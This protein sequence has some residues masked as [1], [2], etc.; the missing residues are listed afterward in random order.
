MCGIAGMVAASGGM[1]PSPDTLRTMLGMIRYRGPDGYGIYTDD[2]AALGQARLSIIDLSSGAQPMSNEDGSIWIVFNGEIFNYV[3]LRDELERLGHRYHTRSD[4]ETIIHAYEQWGDRAWVMFNGQFAAALWDVRKRQLTLARDRVGIAPLHYARVRDARGERIVF[5]SEVK[6]IFAEGGLKPEFDPIG[7][8]RAFT[9]WS[10]PAPTTVWRGV[11]SV[12]PGQVITFDESLRAHSRKFWSLKIDDRSASG[13]TDRD[14]AGDRLESRLQDAVRLRLRADVPVGSYLSGGLDSSVIAHLI[15]RLHTGQLHTFSLRFS[16]PAFDETPQQHR[17]ANI[18]GTDHH[19]IVCDSEAIRN[20]LA[21]VVWHCETPL[22]RLGPVPMYLLSGLVRKTGIKVVMTGEGADEFLCGYHIFRENA[23]RRFWARGP[24]S[25]WRPS[26][27][28]NLHPYITGGNQR[29]AMWMQFFRKNLGA[30]DDPFYSH[31]VRWENSVWTTRLLSAAM[32]ERMDLPHTRATLDDALPPD[33]KNSS[34]LA[35][36]QAIEITTFMSSYLLSSQGD[37]VALGHGVEARFPFLDSEVI[38]CC[39]R[40]P[41]RAKL[42]GMQDKVALRRL[43]S[44][45]L[46][47]DVWKRPKWP[48]RAPIRS[49][50][51]GPD[52]PAEVRDLL[53]RSVTERLGLADTTAVA[54]MVERAVSDK[55]LGEREEMGLVGVLTLH[56]LGTQFGDDFPARVMAAAETLRNTRPDVFIDRR[57]AAS[58]VAAG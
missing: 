39:N 41:R 20:A 32:R 49:A 9:L 42:A 23:A 58:K 36:A 33:W 12:E 45:F 11:T 27:L 48:Y 17:M 38:D 43:A 31:A 1:T 50:L 30:T 53:G 6:S 46:P 24:N 21:E 7:V 57:A 28:A 35:K 3:E 8:W 18:L 13:S 34:P 44:R 52:A 47:E 14:A 22:T 5:G 55:P 19:E 26:L 2:R 25:A 37:R 54:S 16:D 15:R 56:M 4:T 51:F 40:M 29:N 10:S